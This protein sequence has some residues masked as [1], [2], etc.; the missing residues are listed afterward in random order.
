MQMIGQ[1]LAVKVEKKYQDTIEFSNGQK[2]YLDVTWKPEH[3]VTICG[4]VVALPN[5]KWCKNTAG[6]YMKQELEMGDKIYFNYLTV[7]KDNLITGERNVYLLDLEMVFCYVRGKSITAVS[8]HVLI[9]PK[10]NEKKIGSIY[11]QQPKRSEEEGY[12]RHI[13][14]PL[15]GKD[16]VLVSAGDLVRFPER[17][18]F[19]NVIEGK[20]FYVMKQEDLLGK[21]I[22]GGTV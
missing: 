13:G 8:N 7:D 11:V 21:L 14:E 15:K 12:V 19:L 18:S 17:C 6:D 9:E 22:Y 2:L 10:V 5:R 16:R 3:H 1:R 20:E 4:E